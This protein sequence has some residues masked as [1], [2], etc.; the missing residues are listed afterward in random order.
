MILYS[1][2][3]VLV[4]TVMPFAG[5]RFV[6]EGRDHVPTEGPFILIFNHQSIL[7]PALAQT[8]CPRF[9]YS[10]AK[11]TQFASPFWR[12]LLPRIG[13]FPTRRYQVDPQAVRTALRLLD[14]GKGVGIYPEG[15][16]SWDASLQPLRRGTVRLILKAGVPVVPCGIDGS[17][18]IRPR[19]G[20]GLQRGTVT[21]RFG[22]PLNFSAHNVRSE[23]EAA[24]PDATR[25]IENAL[26]EVIADDGVTGNE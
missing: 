22:A 9:V 2:S 13:S 25:R 26:N 8:A 19:W 5:I 23:R 14:E 3:R 1:I 18:H 10:M 21:I 12:W 4:K 15:E 20:G 16:R 24:L 11:S 17:F 7:D 6:V